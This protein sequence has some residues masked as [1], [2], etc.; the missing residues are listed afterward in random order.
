MGNFFSEGLE[1]FPVSSLPVRVKY[2][3]SSQK[4]AKQ[5]VLSSSAL[6]VNFPEVHA[7]TVIPLNNHGRCSQSYQQKHGFVELCVKIIH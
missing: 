2:L 6:T 3:L 7:H 4:L 1:L 5:K